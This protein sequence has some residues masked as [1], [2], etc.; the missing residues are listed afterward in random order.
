MTSIPRSH[1]PIDGD[2]SC[3][4]WSVVGRPPAVHVW[5]DT[6]AT[7]DRWQRASTDLKREGSYAASD[8]PQSLEP[9]NGIKAL[10][11]GVIDSVQVV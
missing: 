1:P 7:D 9:T 4:I 8:Q 10:R 3:G 11:T 2:E 5:T 6:W